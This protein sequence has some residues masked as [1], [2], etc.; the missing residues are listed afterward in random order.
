MPLRHRSLVLGRIA[1]R[2]EQLKIL[3]LVCPAQRLRHDM[4]HGES[5][6]DEVVVAP[7]AEAALL[8]VERGPVHAGA[9]KPL[10]ARPL[11]RSLRIGDVDEH[12]WLVFLDPRYH[13][14]DRHLAEVDPDPFPLEP[15]G[16]NQS[17][18]TSAEGIEDDVAFPRRGLDDPLQKRKGLL[19]GVSRL[20]PGLPREHLHI[21]PD[22]ARLHALG[23]RQV[24]LLANPLVICRTSVLVHWIMQAARVMEFL[25][26]GAV[27]APSIGGMVVALP[28]ELEIR[29]RGGRPEIAAAVWSPAVPVVVAVGP[30]DLLR[31]VRGAMRIETGLGSREVD[32]VIRIALEDLVLP[33]VH[34]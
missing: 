30:R 8:A 5:R 16:G 21:G 26:M 10:V 29:S 18:R 28:L 4:V 24:A 33:A 12:L 1:S 2:A 11:R 14:V 9:G 23:F 7:V 25:H 22:V 20:L 34:P 19:G 32:D 6:R 17:G 13:H 27:A 15:V 31:I 3:L